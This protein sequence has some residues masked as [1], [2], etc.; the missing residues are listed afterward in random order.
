MIRMSKLTDYG[1]VLLAHLARDRELTV[2]SARDLAERSQ[3]PMPTV[4]KLLK[5]LSRAGVLTSHRG[6]NGGY[7]LARSPEQ[8]S[9]GEVIAALEGP[10][11]LTDC[12]THEQG[13]LCTLEGQCPVSRNWQT[14][15]RV[16][17]EA[18][19][20]LSLAQMAGPLTAF[21]AAMAAGRG[22]APAPIHTEKT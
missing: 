4:N 19:D 13:T 20:R 12:G 1:I 16:I 11:T 8:I 6:A 5:E 10:I 18:L 22:R 2:H 15:G 21:P 3:L 14:I 17:R 7:S 9:V